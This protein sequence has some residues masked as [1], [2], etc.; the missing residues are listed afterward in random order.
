MPVSLLLSHL[1][2]LVVCLLSLHNHSTFS[3][4]AP[5][6]PA[7]GQE[8]LLCLN[9]QRIPFHGTIS[10]QR[11]QSSRLPNQQSST[12]NPEGSQYTKEKKNTKKQ[13]QTIHTHTTSW[14]IILCLF[15]FFL[16]ECLHSCVKD[17]LSKRVDWHNLCQRSSW[18][19]PAKQDSYL[20]LPQSPFGQNLSQGLGFIGWWEGTL[21]NKR[22]RGVDLLRMIYIY[23]FLFMS[24]CFNLFLLYSLLQAR[25]PVC[26]C[27]LLLSS[28]LSEEYVNLFVR[29]RLCES[30]YTCTAVWE[31]LCMHVFHGRPLNC[32][33]KSRR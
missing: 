15:L 5:D 28:Y 29:V 23:F 21:H 22:W 17:T 13:K 33:G 32:K 14:A 2:Y 12:V 31:C 24:V 16:F 19:L 26:P 20:L 10:S 27:P 11:S 3:E 6:S 25:W 1:L 7:L 4:S 8:N 18:A 30:V 9:F